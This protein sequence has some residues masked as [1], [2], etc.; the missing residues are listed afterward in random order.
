MT[1]RRGEG[2]HDLGGG[3]SSGAE[4]ARRYFCHWLLVI[5]SWYSTSKYVLAVVQSSQPVEHIQ[6]QGTPARMSGS[7]RVRGEG[8]RPPRYNPTV[9]RFA[10]SRD[11]PAIAVQYRPTQ[12]LNLS[13]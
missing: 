9:K 4:V 8:E 10:Q 6:T 11:K 12:M 3:Y 7:L 5:P 1:K 13:L 2:G